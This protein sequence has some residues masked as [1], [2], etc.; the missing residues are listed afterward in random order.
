MKKSIFLVASVVILTFAGCGESAG[1]ASS[2]DKPEVPVSNGN[3]V[4]TNNSAV[5]GI[6]GLATFPAIPTVPTE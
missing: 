2:V 1:S 5:S 4:V 3:T 6:P